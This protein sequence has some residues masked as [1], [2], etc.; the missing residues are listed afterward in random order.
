[1]VTVTS[2]PGAGPSQS[3]NEMMMLIRVQA[4]VRGFIER[5]KYRIQKIYSQNSSRYFRP[6]EAK[7]TL[8][9]QVFKPDTQLVERQHQYKTGSVYTG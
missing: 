5:R 9:D 1:M 8:T 6:E 3:L 7:E 4:A 2:P